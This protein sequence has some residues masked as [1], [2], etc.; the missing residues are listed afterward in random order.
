MEALNQLVASIVE[1]TIDSL[2]DRGLLVREESDEQKAARM[3]DGKLELSLDDLKQHPSCGWSR[4]RALRLL[5]DGCIEDL[6]T[7][8]RSYRIS[9]LS[10]YRFLTNGNASKTGRDMNKPPAKRKR[11]SVSPLSN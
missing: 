5:R 2:H 7:S 3:F 9:S 8:T 11:N 6:G 10:V 1:Q 4:K